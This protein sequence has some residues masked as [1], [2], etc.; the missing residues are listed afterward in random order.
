[1]VR[2]YFE[3]GAQGDVANGVWTGEDGSKGEIQL[4]LTSD[5]TLQLV[6]SLTDAGNVNAPA[7]GTVALVRKRLP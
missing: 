2:F 5:N 3:G 4:K 7:S 6:W 1:M